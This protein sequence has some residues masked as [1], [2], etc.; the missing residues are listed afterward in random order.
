MTIPDENSSSAVTLNP[1]SPC[2]GRCSTAYGDEICRGCGRT[3][4]EVIN[5]IVYTDEEKAAVW[6]RLRKA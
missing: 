3:F 6:A 5:W 2:V 4:E 1:D